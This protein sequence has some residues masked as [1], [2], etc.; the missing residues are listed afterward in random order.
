MQPVTC[1]CRG[2][3]KEQNVQLLKDKIFWPKYNCLWSASLKK[4]K[5]FITVAAGAGTK[6]IFVLYRQ[7]YIH[8]ILINK[9]LPCIPFWQECI[10]ALV[11]V[12][13]KVRFS[14]W[15]KLIKLRP[16]LHSILST[17]TILFR[18]DPIWPRQLLINIWQSAKY[19]IYIFWDQ[20]RHNKFLLSDWVLWYLWLNRR[21]R[22]QW[23]LRLI[24]IRSLITTKPQ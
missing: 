10:H 6:N 9:A 5:R 2:F 8:I 3:L 19:P 1:T 12:S 17:I 20:L 4:V 15:H 16:I 23:F 21:I 11:R 18:A 24:F 7:S 14:N 22:Q 13:A